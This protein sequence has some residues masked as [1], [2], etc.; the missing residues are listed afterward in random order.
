MYPS[1]GLTMQTRASEYTVAVARN[2][3]L[4]GN[5]VRHPDT[6]Q[7]TQQQLGNLLVVGRSTKPS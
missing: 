5:T 6:L 3:I 4:S 1:G 2:L 7:H